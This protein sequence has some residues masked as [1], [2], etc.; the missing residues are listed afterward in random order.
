MASLVSR[1]YDPL[2]SRDLEG[3]GEVVPLLVDEFSVD[4]VW[5]SLT[6]FSLLAYNSSQESKHSLLACLALFDLRDELAAS[7]T[8]AI[9]R[10][11]RAVADARAPWSEPPI[12]EVP[13]EEK[14][15]PL[16]VLAGALERRDGLITERWIASRRGETLDRDLI[17]AASR[18]PG[19][20]GHN[21]IIAVAVLR[22]SRMFGKE[23]EW[24]F[25]RVIAVEWSAGGATGHIEC[26]VAGAGLNTELLNECVHV[27][28]ATAGSASAFHALELFDAGVQ[29]SRTLETAE[30]C[31]RIAGHVR[32]LLG[33]AETG[34]L[35]S[36]AAVQPSPLY[37]Y[38][39][40]LAQLLLAYTI[41][42]R[43]RENFA[44][45]LDGV[46]TACAYNLA[47]CSKELR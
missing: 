40:D 24:G 38:S 14:P 20:A 12:I 47:E 23:F 36:R 33:E 34:R 7:N 30:A 19:D 42:K 16:E 44:V 5:R 22:L 43:L 6:R 45:S 11:A 37:D 8:D 25:L 46:I 35:A 27:I 28:E 29:A 13:V 9:V 10:C 17:D 21:L 1:L 3:I 4:E 39:D 18:W 31:R 2:I 32:S 41:Q 26:S 15:L